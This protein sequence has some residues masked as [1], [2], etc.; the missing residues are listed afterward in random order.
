MFTHHVFFWLKEDLSQE[1]VKKFE[2]VVKSLLS[3]GHLSTGDLGK[4]A[5]TAR[6]V[7]DRSYSYSLLLQFKDQASHDAYQVDPIHLHFVD[8]C[9]SY[10]NKVLIYDSETV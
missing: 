1:E 5:Q 10:W 4:P 3:I 7:I 2:T 6:P 8:Q 9:S